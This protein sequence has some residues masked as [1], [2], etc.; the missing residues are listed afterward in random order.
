MSPVLKRKS[1][2]WKVFVLL[3]IKS[4][5]TFKRVLSNKTTSALILFSI[6][7]N[8]GIAIIPNKTLAGRNVIHFPINL[9]KY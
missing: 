6:S 1:L 9:F 2:Y 4:S 5:K 8:V 7:F 3:D